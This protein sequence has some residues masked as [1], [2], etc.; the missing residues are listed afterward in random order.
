MN[1]TTTPEREGDGPPVMGVAILI[2]V[3]MAGMF[4]GGWLAVMR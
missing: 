3:F 4:L 1:D 2:A